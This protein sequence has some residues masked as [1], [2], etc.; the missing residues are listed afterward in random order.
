M[1]IK[2][3]RLSSG[4]LFEVKFGP[5]NTAYTETN[6][7]YSAGLIKGTATID[8]NREPL[9][10]LAGEPEMLQACDTI[11][12]NGTIKITFAETALDAIQ[13][14][15]GGGTKST[16]AADGAKA[17][18][19]EKIRLDGTAYHKLNYANISSVTVTT[20]DATPVSILETNNWAYDATHGRIKRIAGGLI[21]D[22]D[23]VYVNYTANVPQYDLLTVGGGTD[24]SYFALVLF[25]KKRSTSARYHVITFYKVYTGK[26]TRQFQER[27]WNFIEVEFKTSCD[28]TRDLNDML[29]RERDELVA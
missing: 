5:L 12:E 26:V 13:R 6:C 11:A 9:E 16:I 27:G 22:G 20:D 17:V 23:E 28:S 7:P 25:K 10:L 19:S 14:Y 18:T 8:L 21:A 4:T 2:E 3:G 29:Y 1:L 15:I 24:R